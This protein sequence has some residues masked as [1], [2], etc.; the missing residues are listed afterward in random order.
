MSSEAGKGGDRRPMQVTQEQYGSNYQNIYGRKWEC[1]SLKGKVLKAGKTFEEC[2][3]WADDNLL[4]DKTYS[5][6]EV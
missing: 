6:V 5:I 1:R 3:E 4:S 2:K